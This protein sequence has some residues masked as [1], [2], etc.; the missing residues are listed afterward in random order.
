MYTRGG[1]GMGEYEKTGN[2][3]WEFFPPPYA[4]L[5]PP[6]SAPMPAPVI[7]GEGRGVGCTGVGCTGGCGCNG[8][9]GGARRG[10]G[11][12]DLAALVDSVKAQLAADTV[13]AGVPN[14][15]VGGVAL[16]LYAMAAGTPGVSRR[17]N[18]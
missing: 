2:W 12:G 15:V 18:T 6:D 14:W 3:S 7:T 9:C 10:P 11:L 5:A 8:A 17:R 1:R 13:I 4:F 16:A